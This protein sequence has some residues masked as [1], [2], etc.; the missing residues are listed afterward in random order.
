MLALAVREVRA[1]AEAE[2]NFEELEAAIAKVGR[3]AAALTEVT[4]WANTVQSSG[5]KIADRV[6]KVRE[7]LEKQIERL[8]DHVARLKTSVTAGTH[9]A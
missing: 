5:K 7:D 1:S 4:T 3:D 8:Q 9:S 6:E 2:A